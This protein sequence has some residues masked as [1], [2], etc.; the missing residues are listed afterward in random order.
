MNYFWTITVGGVALATITDIVK[1][2]GVSGGPHITTEQLAAALGGTGAPLY[3]NLGN[4]EIVRRFTM[5]REHASD[6]DAH[7][8]YQIGGPAFAGVADVLLTHVDIAGAS[9]SW[10][11]A[12]AKV[13]IQVEPP[14][15]PTTTTKITITGG[16][17][18]LTN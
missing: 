6:T 1:P 13:E 8:W 2:E 12:A 3:Q 7:A 11:V 14:V 10:T 15:G 9:A 16:P 5:T 18:V 17:A 4:V